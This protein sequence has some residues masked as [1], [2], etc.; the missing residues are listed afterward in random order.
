MG[1]KRIDCRLSL[2]VGLSSVKYGRL[3]HGAQ[4]DSARR[5]VITQSVLMMVMVVAVF[6]ERVE[7]V[8]EAEVTNGSM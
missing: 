1:R 8:L 7:K 4:V 3:L 2:G 5:T 6:I